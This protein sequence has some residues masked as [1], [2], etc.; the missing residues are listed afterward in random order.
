VSAT[1]FSGV[2][3]GV[4]GER[5]YTG[6]PPKTF[7]NDEIVFEVVAGIVVREWILDLCAVRD[8][9]SE[10]FRQSIPAFLLKQVTD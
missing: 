9:T 3:R 5:G 4:S 6:Y 8:Q 2:I 7:W 1:W 10:E